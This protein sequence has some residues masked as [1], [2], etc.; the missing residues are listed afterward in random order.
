MTDD[1]PRE[2]VVV[3]IPC[4][5]ILDA[6]WVAHM[7]AWFGTSKEHPLLILWEQTPNR[8]D[9]SF[10]RVIH[11]F[12]QTDATWLLLN[13]ADVLPE[14]PIDEEWRFATENLAQGWAMSASPVT[15]VLGSLPVK[16]TFEN[17]KDDR[18]F[19]VQGVV[20][21]HWW[22]HRSIV[23]RLPILAYLNN[24][25][26]TQDPLYV[27]VP[28]ER[29]EDFDMCQRMISV[30][31]R[32]C[33]DPRMNTLHRKNDLIPSYRKGIPIIDKSRIE[34]EPAP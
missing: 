22:I 26:H 4:P 9:W 33:C 29:S 5:R 32:I 14:T 8:M 30:G 21:G 3:G 20:G 28:P 2:K 27:I 13:D 31:A 18:A 23:E 11:R 1:P 34:A 25:D 15:S 17:I 6:S 24:V 10:S 12:L 16:T 7:F 19:E